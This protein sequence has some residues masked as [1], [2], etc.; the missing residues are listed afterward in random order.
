MMA[1]LLLTADGK[2][3]AAV[4]TTLSTQRNERHPLALIPFVY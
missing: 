3:I 1:R 2:D 4:L